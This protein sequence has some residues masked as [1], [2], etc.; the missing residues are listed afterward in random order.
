MDRP[1]GKK[2]KAVSDSHACVLAGI[3]GDISEI[4]KLSIMRECLNASCKPD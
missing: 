1:F 2:Q 4:Q 3:Y